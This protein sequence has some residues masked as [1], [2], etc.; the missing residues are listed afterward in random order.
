MKKIYTLL[1]IT[2]L[3]SSCKNIQK[4]VDRGEY[5]KAIFYA[6]EKLHGKKNKKTKHVRALEEAFL[7][8]NQRDLDRIDFLNAKANPENYDRV[9]DAYAKI[10]KRQEKI[11]AFLPL[12]S[13]DGYMA[14]FDF[15][16]VND[17]MA[18][19]AEL[20]MAYHYE[21]AELLLIQA[22]SGDKLAARRAYD[23][24]KLTDKYAMHYKDKRNLMKEAHYLGTTR[25]LVNLENAAPVIM[26]QE[27]EDHVMSM[28][29][30]GL[31]S[32]WVEYYSGH[33]D[34]LSMDIMATLKLSDLDV[35]PE[36]ER[37]EVHVDEREIKDG[38]VY[39]DKKKITVDSLGKETVTIE[40]VKRDKFITV[41]AEVR[42]I[43]R[44]KRA[45][46]LGTLS[47]LD[48]I[49]GEVLDV[50]SFK[51][52]AVFEERGLDYWGDSRALCGKHSSARSHIE[53]FPSDYELA[54]VAAENMKHSFVNHLRTFVF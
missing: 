16:E 15:I 42:E 51:V 22:E 24:L 25:V 33:R 31:N 28:N 11:S 53:D 20:A 54:M 44:E 10:K 41:R 46:A 29:L 32:F 37:I 6:A 27:F 14:H 38:F 4:M 18:A 40:K 30:A 34:G 7:K 2:L 45:V 50:E 9:F 52:N 43:F 26:P 12:V 3:I 47:Y 21:Q 8:V 36:S 23:R 17:K 48:M 39:V 5:D 13:K 49:S 19:V 35:G 1:V